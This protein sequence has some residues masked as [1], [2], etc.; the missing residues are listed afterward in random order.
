[1]KI[2][3]RA[4]RRVNLFLRDDAT[5]APSA[6]STLP[7]EGSPGNLMVMALIADELK[8]LARILILA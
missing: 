1:M 5:H 4:E 2:H 7:V 3:A 8:W 6:S